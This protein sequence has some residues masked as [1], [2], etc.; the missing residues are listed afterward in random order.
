MARDI[1]Y[2]GRLH[3][4]GDAD[5]PANLPPALDPARYPIIATHWFGVGPFRPI[6]ELTAGIVA[7]VR[8]RR[9][10]MRV[11]GNGVRPIGE[12]LDEIAR[13][14]GLSTVIAEKLEIYAS[15]SD[16]ALD[17][18]GGRELPPLPLHEVGA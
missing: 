8:S 14:Y 5:T 16:D 3:K 11:H 4:G 12:L 9:N 17:A 13:E 10:L 15:L 6:G 7:N 18:T 1:A 2:V